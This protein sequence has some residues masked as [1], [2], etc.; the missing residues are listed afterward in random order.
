MNLMKLA[1]EE[2]QQDGKWTDR[3]NIF[4]TALYKGIDESK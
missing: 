4:R 2:D 3:K 1:L